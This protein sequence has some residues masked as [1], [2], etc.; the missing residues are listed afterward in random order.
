MMCAPED[1][2]WAE[3]TGNCEGIFNQHTANLYT[4]TRKDL[5]EILDSIQACLKKVP[6]CDSRSTG[7]S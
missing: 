5:E 3:E 4:D 7:L 1:S 6:V 2:R